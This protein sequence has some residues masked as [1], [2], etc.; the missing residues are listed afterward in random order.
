MVS[1]FR[2]LAHE[3]RVAGLIPAADRGRRHLAVERVKSVLPRVAFEIASLGVNV[4]EYVQVRREIERFRPHLLYKRHSRFDVA[5]LAAAR[6]LN[7]PS[8]L[9]VNCLF[10]APRYEEFEPLAMPRTARTLERRALELA[11][12]VVAVSTPLAQDVR[13]LADT[14]VVVLPNGADPER[15]DRR[16]FDGSRI[17]AQYGLAGVLTIGWVGI[18]REWHGLELLLDVMTAVP[19]AV[20]LIVGDGPAR[21]ALDRRVEQLALTRRIVITGRV[22]H[23]TM[24][25]YVAAMDIAVVPDERTGVASPMKLLEYMSMG[26]AVVAPRA[27]NIRDLIDEDVDGLLFEPGDTHEL[28][29]ALRRLAEDTH[30]RAALGACARSKVE[31]ERNWRHIAQT[32]LTA[33]GTS[34]RLAAPNAAPPLTV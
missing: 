14:R 9:E 2:A 13:A 25:D 29:T 7:V 27:D 30:L 23:E 6:H 34:S 4:V 17:R 15:F 26:R 22:P 18:L 1:A 11:D 19:E 12:I 21:V 33:V 16:K 3:V 31:R 24:P 28:A 10:T 20:L 8:V 32:V 5:A